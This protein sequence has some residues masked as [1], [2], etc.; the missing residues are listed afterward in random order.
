MLPNPKVKGRTQCVQNYQNPRFRQATQRSAVLLLKIKIPTN[1]PTNLIPNKNPYP[2]H[3]QTQNSNDVHIT[4]QNYQ[5]PRF[6]QATR[7]IALFAE[8]QKFQ[9][10]I[11]ANIVLTKSF[12]R[13]Q[14]S[15]KR[16]QHAQNSV[17]L[18]TETFKI[19][20]QA[21]QALFK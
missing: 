2:K 7:T 5:N 14:N 21:T 3:F 6:R 8:N 20:F 12:F 11:Q 13:T 15:K 9:Q 17:T 18:F 16:T 4:I 10:I 1:Y 19:V